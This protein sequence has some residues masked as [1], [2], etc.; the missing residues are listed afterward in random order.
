MRTSLIGLSALAAVASATYTLEDDYTTDA[1]ASMFDFFTVRY[2]ATLDST[3]L[4]C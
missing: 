3:M 2:T 4:T 1:F